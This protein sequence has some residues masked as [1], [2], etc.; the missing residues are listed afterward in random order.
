MVCLVLG[1]LLMGYGA[2]I[3]FG[4]N[5]GGFFVGKHGA[6]R[7]DRRCVVSRSVMIFSGAM[8]LSLHAWVWWF[9]AIWGTL[10]GVVLR[11]FF[12]LSGFDAVCLCVGR[13]ARRRVQHLGLIH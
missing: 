3:A 11:P 5:I 6:G 2:R 7:I 13:W 8:S 9:C 4:C 10:L 1:G 12:G